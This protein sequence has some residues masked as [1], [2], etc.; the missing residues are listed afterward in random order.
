MA[1]LTRTAISLSL[2]KNKA[3]GIFS[4][5]GGDTCHGEKTPSGLNA[6]G[7]KYL[8]NAIGMKYL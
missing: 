6:V 2:E 8:L 4:V 5:A 7:M 3:I 1:C